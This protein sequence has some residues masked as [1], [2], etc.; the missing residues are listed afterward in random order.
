MKLGMTGNR[1]GMSST[2]KTK[3]IEFITNNK[4]DE[5]HHG[6]CV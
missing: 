5:V 6:D 3:L 1:F 4:I 2:A